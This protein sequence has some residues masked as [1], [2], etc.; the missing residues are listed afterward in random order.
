MINPKLEPF[1]V[2]VGEW[3]A[4]GK[5]RLLPGTALHAHV[6][7]DWIEDGAFLRMRSEAEQA[8]IPSGVFIFGG[9]DA[10]AEVTL[11]Y[12]DERGVSRILATTI[13]SKGWRCWRNAPG[14]S[15]R[16]TGTF[17]DQNNT[18]HVL[19]ELSEDG[20]TWVNDLEQTYTRVV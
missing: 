15:Q 5:H 4:V 1:G 2:L 10:T 17:A 16:L 3:D 18:I 19:W 20:A 14:F 12:F 9:D 8:A 6:T 11:L 13:D 7:V